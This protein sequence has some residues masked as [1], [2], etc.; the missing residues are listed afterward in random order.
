MVAQPLQHVGQQMRPHQVLHAQGTES[1][2]LPTTSAH[3]VYSNMWVCVWL[4]LRQI[5]KQRDKARSGEKLRLRRYMY[6]PAKVAYQSV[7]WTIPSSRE[8]SGRWQPMHPPLLPVSIKPPP[9]APMT[10]IPPSNDVNLY[11]CR[12][13]LFAALL[14]YMGPPLSDYSKASAGV[15]V[16]VP[17]LCLVCTAT[18][19]VDTYL[20]YIVPLEKYVLTVTTISESAH[21]RSAFSAVVRLP[22]QSSANDTMA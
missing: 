4:R 10:R 2:L 11:P 1:S 17:N 5:E 7:P 15:T 19:C 3:A 21:M 22:R 8:P 13:K 14:L 16:R 18:T 6:V 9:I 12:G 20:L